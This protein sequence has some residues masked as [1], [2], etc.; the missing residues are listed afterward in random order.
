MN[1]FKSG[2]TRDSLGHVITSINMIVKSYCLRQLK[3][4]YYRSISEGRSA[5]SI[6]PDAQS[7]YYL[8]VL[9]RLLW[10]ISQQ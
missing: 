5:R 9:F 2:R 10:G 4:S 1:F 6:S 7:S 8:K 3:L